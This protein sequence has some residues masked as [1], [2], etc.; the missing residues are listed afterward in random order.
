VVGV[1]KNGLMFRVNLLT[2]NGHKG[3]HNQ[4]SGPLIETAMKLAHRNSFEDEPRRHRQAAHVPVGNVYYYFRPRKNGEAVVERRLAQFRE[5]RESG[6]V[7]FSKDGCCFCGSIHGN[8]AACAWGMSAGQLVFRVTKGALAKAAALFTEPMGWLELFR[9][10]AMKRML[11]TFA[12]LFCAF[13]VWLPG[14]YAA[15]DPDLVV[16]E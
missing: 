13:R 8:R 11:R 6:P 4:T 2:H 1:D 5:F 14:G 16:M 9:R 10:P 15:N 3:D 12:H 7:E